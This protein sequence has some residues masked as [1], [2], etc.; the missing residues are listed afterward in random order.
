M[1]I[2]V[3]ALSDGITE[4]FTSVM[5]ERLGRRIRLLCEYCLVGRVPEALACCSGS[6]ASCPPRIGI[7]QGARKRHYWRW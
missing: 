1:K 6:K 5:V 4:G 2:D 3:I 7:V